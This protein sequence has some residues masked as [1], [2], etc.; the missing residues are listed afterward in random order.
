MTQK[1]PT[2]IRSKNIA[3]LIGLLSFIGVVYV[4]SI[5]RMQEGWVPKNE[6]LQNQTQTKS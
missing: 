4:L 2:H 5:I 1:L 3:I 6:T